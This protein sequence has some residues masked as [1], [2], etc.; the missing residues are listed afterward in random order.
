MS[1]VQKRIQKT[2][3]SQV[4]FSQLTR[5]N[6]LG[7]DVGYTYITVGFMGFLNHVDFWAMSDFDL[8]DTEKFRKPGEG[9]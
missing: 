7:L 4:T 5:D 6:E 3:E 9:L 1:F 8:I 2:S